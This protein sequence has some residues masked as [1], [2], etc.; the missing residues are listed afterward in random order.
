MLDSTRNI[1][2]NQNLNF[3]IPRTN[4][5]SNNEAKPETIEDSFTSSKPGSQYLILPPKDKQGGLFRSNDVELK[6]MKVEVDEKLP[7]VNGYLAKLDDS[8]KTELA[9][10]GYIVFEDKE[11]NWY[12]KDPS[13]MT[14]SD[15][16]KAGGDEDIKLVERP[17][18]TE[19]RFDTPLTRKY[20]GKGVGIAVIDSGVYPHPDFTSPNNRIVAFKD[21]VNDMKIPYDDGG[22]G[23]HVAGDAAGNGAMSKGLYRG[24]APDAGI[25]GLKALKGSGGGKTSDVIKSIQ[26]CIQNKEKYNIRVINMSLGH[27]AY[28]DF[29]QDPTN[30]AI[31]KAYE[32]GIVVVTSAG[33]SGPKPGTLTAPG[34]SPHAISV[35]AADDNNTPR[36]P[37]DDKI[38]DFSSRGPAKSGLMKPDL[39]APGEAIISTLSP[40][41]EDSSR[42]SNQLFNVLKWLNDMPDEALTR[43]PP[44]TLKMFGFAD[45]TIERWMTSS[46]QARKEMKRIFRAVQKTPLVDNSYVGKPGTS[47]A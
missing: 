10:A 28:D 7:I 21:F 41:T 44:D 1:G 2:G 46:K 47:M 18:L 31:R 8:K 37:S 12:P 45:S 11:E 3:N 30:L 42:R 27:S 24:T 5:S 29:T 16:D 35:G 20:T 13:Q 9:K 14:L 4:L 17:K 34:D 25:I 19:P 26:W 40:G 32:H 22:H 33:N 38:T 6:K 23:T 15:I 39:V 36:D 43:I